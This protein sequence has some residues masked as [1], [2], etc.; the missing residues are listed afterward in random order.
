[1]KEADLVARE[2]S[3]HPTS[4]T[5]TREMEVGWG[6]NMV[7]MDVSGFGCF[8]S[9]FFYLLSPPFF[10]HPFSLLTLDNRGKEKKER[11]PISCVRF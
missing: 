5:T 10:F 2:G 9:C 8:V 3:W 11:R 7:K 1:M 4:F 6:G